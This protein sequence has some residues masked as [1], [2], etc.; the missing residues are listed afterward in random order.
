MIK[1]LG[2]MAVLKINIIIYSEYNNKNKE[3]IQNAVLNI[4]VMKENSNGSS[5]KLSS[6]Y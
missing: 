2:V 3:K 1:I 6:I 5:N 4:R